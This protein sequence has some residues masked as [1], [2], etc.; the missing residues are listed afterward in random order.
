M[1]RMMSH[2]TRLQP[3][4]HLESSLRGDGR[5]WWPLLEVAPTPSPLPGTYHPVAALRFVQKGVFKIC[6]NQRHQETRQLHVAP[7]G[8]LRREDDMLCPPH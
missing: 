1:A 3:S 5:G 2:P 4:P 7:E 6:P 8:S